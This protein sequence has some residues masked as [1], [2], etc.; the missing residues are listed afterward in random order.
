MIKTGDFEKDVRNGYYRWERNH[1]K[2]P[3][4]RSFYQDFDLWLTLQGVPAQYLSKVSYAAYDR[5]HSSGE[6]GILDCAYDF[7][8]IFQS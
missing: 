5:G 7:I 8:R 6:E 2:N 4:N 3:K 1:Y